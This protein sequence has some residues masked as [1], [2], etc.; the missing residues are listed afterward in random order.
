MCVRLIGGH[1]SQRHSSKAKLKIGFYLQ[2]QETAEYFEERSRLARLSLLFDLD[3]TLTDSKEGIFRCIRYALEQLGLSRNSEEDLNWCIGPPLQKSLARL[4]G[5]PMAPKALELYRERYTEKGMFENRVY[6][7]IPES[8]SAL[9]GKADLY[10]ATSKP[11]VYAVEV[12]RH[13]HL[14][15]YFKGIYGSELDGALSEKGELIGFLLEREKI[16]RV[17]AFMIGDRKHDMEGARKNAVTGIG[18]GWGFGTPEELL[19]SGALN[20]LQHPGEL[21]DYFKPL[22]DF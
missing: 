2:I 18:A 14:N 16:N 7:G 3:G 5:D 11:R 22:M 13:F 21:A 4:V 1:S 20:I 17:S 6:E 19:D 9:Q 10:V 15:G 12:I 8:L